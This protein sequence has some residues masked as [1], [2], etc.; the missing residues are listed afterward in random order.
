MTKTKNELLISALVEDYK[1]RL[2]SCDKNRSTAYMQ[3]PVAVI[4]ALVFAGLFVFLY[5][6]SSGWQP[7]VL[8]VMAVCTQ[9]T[10]LAALVFMAVVAQKRYIAWINIKSLHKAATGDSDI[11]AEHLVTMYMDKINDLDHMLGK[12]EAL[13][14]TGMWLVY[15]YAALG[16]LTTCLGAVLVYT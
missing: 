11:S 6:R 4:G 2:A 12:Q 7:I 3:M 16:L 15:S 8:T 5:P 13:L 14:R 1:V 9:I 10:V